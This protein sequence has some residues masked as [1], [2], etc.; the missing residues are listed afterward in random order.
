[1]RVNILA[2][3]AVKIRVRVRVRIARIFVDEGEYFGGEPVE[4]GIRVS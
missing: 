4:F 3:V 1:M 2:A